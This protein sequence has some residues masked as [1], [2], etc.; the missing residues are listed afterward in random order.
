[1]TND[2]ITIEVD[3]Q[4]AILTLNRPDSLNASDEEL[5]GRLATV[6]EEVAALEGVR[7]AVLTGA[8][9][10]F[11][12]GGNL[13]L[14]QRMVDDTSVRAAIMAEAEQIVRA[15]VGF[16]LPWSPPSTVRRSVSAAAW[17][18]SPTWS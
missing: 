7:A 18:V 4:V 9:E 10:A 5:H 16:P 1:M 15:L 12:A 3:G 17:R 13:H 11:S 14:L 8:G 2:A 6:W